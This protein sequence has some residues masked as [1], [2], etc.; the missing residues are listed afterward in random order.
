MKTITKL[1]ILAMLVTMSFTGIAQA[2]T[3][4]DVNETAWYYDYV[5]ELVSQGVLSGYDNGTFGPEDDLTRA[6]AAKVVVLAFIG[7][8]DSSYDAGFWDVSDDAWYEDYVNTAAMY[9]ITSGYTD[10]NGDATGEFGPDDDITRAAFVKMVVSAAGLDPD[11]TGGPHF[12]DVDPGAWYYGY[13]ETAY[14][15][16]VV[17]GYDDGSFGPGNNVNRAEASKVTVNGQNPESRPSGDDDDDD[18]DE[19]PEGYEVD[20]DLGV[21]VDEDGCEEDYS[22]DGSVCVDGNGCELGEDWDADAAECVVPPN[23]GTLLVEMGEVVSGSSVPKGATSIEMLNVTFTASGDDIELDG[24]TVHRT[25][26]GAPADFDFLYLYD[27][28]ERLTYGRSIANDDNEATFGSLNIDLSD[29]ES[30]TLTVIA[31]F[32]STATTGDE[33]ALEIVNVD[34]INSDAAEVTGVFPMEGEV[35]SIAGASAGTI[36]ISKQGSVPDPTIGEEAAEVAEFQLTAASENMAVT[37]IS[38]TVK[39]V[40]NDSLANLQLMQGSDVLAIASEVNNDDLV[41]FEIEGNYDCDD[42]N[43]SGDGYCVGKGNSRTFNVFADITDSAD[44]ADTLK[45]YLDESTDLEAV[46]LSYGFGAQVTYGD[47]DNSADDGTDAT[48]STIQ[49]GQFT[50]SNNGPNSGDVAINAED[51]ILNKMTFTSEGNV[52]IRQL[53]ATIT[54]DTL[55]GSGL[56][57]GVVA[58]F[59]DIKL[60]RLD[61]EDNVVETLMGP[62][63]LTVGGNDGSQTVTWT[64]SWSMD[65]GESVDVAI[66]CDVANYTSLDST[67]VYATLVAISGT[68]GIRN[69]DTNEYVPTDD[70]VPSS[71]IAG[72]IMT[73][74]SASLAIAL[75]SYPTS[76]TFVKGSDDVNLARFTFTAGDAMDVTVSSIVLAGYLDEDGD[77]TYTQGTDNSVDIKNVVT[78][79]WLEDEDGNQL[80][81]ARSFSAG[82]A[83]FNALAWTIEAG[84]TEVLNVYGD[85]S[86]SAFYNSTNDFVAVDIDSAASDITSE[87]VEGN[88]LTETGDNPNGTATNPN[89]A[90]TISGGGTFAI[91]EATADP[92]ET[93][94]AAQGA[95]DLLVG[96]FKLTA[97][98]EDFEVKK[99]T[100]TSAGTVNGTAVTNIPTTDPT[101]VDNILSLTLKYPTDVDDPDNLNG[102]KEISM[103]GTNV[104]F[105]NLGVMVPKDDSVYVELYANLNDHNRD[106]GGLDSDDGMTFRLNTGDAE[107]E[108]YGDFSATGQGSGTGYT[109]DE[110]SDVTLSNTTYVYRTIPTVANDTS[111]GSSLILGPNQEVYRF[112]VSAD[113]NENVVLQYLTLDVSVTGIT[114]GNSVNSLTN[115]ASEDAFYTDGYCGSPPATAGATYDTAPWYITQY[116]LSTVVGT[117]C[118]DPY[119]NVAK[120]ELNSSNGTANSGAI[121]GQGSS[122]TFSVYADL[123]DA[124]A[125]IA[126]ETISIRIHNDTTYYA[127]TT[128]LGLKGTNVTGLSTTGMIWSDYGASSGTHGAQ[129]SEWMT[130]YKVP[131]MP[132]SYVT[133][134]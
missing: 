11:S 29:G 115:T 33:N 13:V 112:T 40:S 109:E 64:D 30:I 61:D 32:A 92:I 93:Q 119:N 65:A 22:Y 23:V 84:T 60:V 102:E 21:C 50:I 47:Y 96:R 46:G 36:T 113:S 104:K 125:N 39:G 99:L 68:D 91:A 105:T 70:I 132:V 86:N 7:E 75:A 17:D 118:Y 26:V 57:D 16:S 74:K 28:A 83:T 103:S 77:G 48:H 45:L 34:K 76:D 8:V 5:E 89:V 108:A 116:G 49:G 124:N 35:F 72:N 81:N 69:S 94:I 134:S 71:A 20:Q 63:E 131:G 130:G 114:T 37:R 4:Y 90:M 67:T 25:G 31:D 38:L 41:V 51:A 79:V 9:G 117:G 101:T 44:R 15:N 2:Q 6:Q 95:E 121:V 97:A 100:F 120:F 58:N 14:N 52:E 87:D 12:S 18:D 27:G 19:C 82:D 106:G 73:A 123:Y 111:L 98:D 88:S 10:D 42:Y 43:H 54:A 127:A 110:V 59:T 56:V 55:T 53:Q 122:K 62:A 126:N 128:L 85:V 80:D 78:S 24:F 1:L 133:L 129:T 3:F 107:G 66:T